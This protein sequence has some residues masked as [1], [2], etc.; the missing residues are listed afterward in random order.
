MLKVI[1]AN[2]LADGIVVYFVSAGVWTKEIAK[3]MT[4]EPESDI[5]AALLLAKADVKNHLVVDPFE[6]EVQL[7]AAEGLE[8]VSLRN[9]I[10]AKGPTVDFLPHTAP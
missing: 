9:A 2:G 4:F 5:A 10:R 3:A 6:V 1:S 8:A 7:S